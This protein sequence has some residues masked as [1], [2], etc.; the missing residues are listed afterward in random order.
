[1]LGRHNGRETAGTARSGGTTGERLWELRA[2]EAQFRHNCMDERETATTA[3][4]GGTTGERLRELRA[5]ETTGERLWELRARETQ[6]ERDCG[7]CALGRHNCGGALYKRTLP[8][9]LSGRGGGS[10]LSDFL[11]D[12]Q[13]DFLL[14]DQS[15]FLLDDQSD[16]PPPPPPQ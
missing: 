16:S 8:I 1:M 7:N 3:R 2:R 5:R 14:D 11:L 15:D 10:K 12:D 9:T 13:S 6:L 4:S